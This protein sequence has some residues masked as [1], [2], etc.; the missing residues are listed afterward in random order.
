MQKQAYAI[1]STFISTSD[2]YVILVLSAFL[3]LNVFKVTVFNNFI[4]PDRAAS[5]FQYKFVVTFLALSVFYLAAFGIKA[6][7]VIAAGYLLQT[8][9]ILVNMS[10]FIYFNSYISPMQWFALLNE[11]FLAASHSSAPLSLKLLIVFIDL[12]ALIYLLVSYSNVHMASKRLYFYRYMAIVLAL[13]A[14]TCIE[15]RNYSNGKSL[16]EYMSSKYTGESHIVERYGT[17]VNGAVNLV[18]SRNEGALISNF[19]YGHEVAVSEAVQ[20]KPNFVIIQMESVDSNAITQKHQGAYI[21]PYL[22]SLSDASIFYPYTLSYHEGGGTS[23]VEFSVISSIEPLLRFPAIK[24]ASYDYPNSMLP[25]LSQAAYNTLAFHGN[26]GNFFNRNTAFP[27]M[28]FAQFYDISKMKLSD[29]GWGAPDSEVFNFAAEH[30]KNVE[31]PFLSYII[32]MTNHGP[33]INARNYY[34][35]TRYDDIADETARNYYNSISY[36]DQCVK[37]FVGHIQANYKNTY[38]F[39]F[40]DHAPGIST[41]QYHEASFKMNSMNVEF[42]PLFIITPDKKIYKEDKQV[43]CFLDI[44]PTILYNAGIKFNLRTDGKNLITREGGYD[45]IPFKG[46]EYDRAFLFDEIT[47]QNTLAKELK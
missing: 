33:F 24:L 43:A 3:L 29:A 31:Q 7:L 44:S 5:A 1:K 47:R 22:N 13:L 2:R 42:V 19:V 20:D 26:L 46:S 11:G 30:L 28:G 40:G 27:K 35:N 36:V 32:T 38:I 37:E 39:L 41:G 6:R 14:L 21:A 17:V 8:V 4:V 34:N 23:D 10:Y 9:Y 15:I 25:R 16:A 12:P 18:K 45:I